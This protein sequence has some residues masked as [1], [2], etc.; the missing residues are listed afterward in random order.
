MFGLITTLLTLQGFGLGACAVGAGVKSCLGKLDGQDRRKDIKVKKLYHGWS[1]LVEEA[2][3][4]TI[5]GRY[6]GKVRCG[7]IDRHI[8]VFGKTEEELRHDIDKAVGQL[9][10]EYDNW[11]KIH[12]HWL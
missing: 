3:Y 9:S 11:K 1:I 2:Y 5:L 7:A 12:L 8:N 10:Q 4:D 6:Y